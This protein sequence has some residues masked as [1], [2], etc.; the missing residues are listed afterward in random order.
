MSTARLVAC[1]AALVNGPL[2][3]AQTVYM[4]LLH[5]W[6]FPMSKRSK[7]YPSYKTKYR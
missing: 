5:V 6:E 1:R 7:V 2:V 3:E 4:V